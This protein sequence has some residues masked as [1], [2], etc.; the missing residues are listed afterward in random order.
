[1]NLSKKILIV[2]NCLLLFVS[3]L[4]AQMPSPV[5]SVRDGG[6]EETDVSFSRSLKFNNAPL[7]LIL[8][9]YSLVT[10]FTLLMAPGLPKVNITLKSQVP[11]TLDEYLQAIEAVLTMNG[12]G[13]M[14][15]GDSFVK[16]V[17]VK[18][19]LNTAPIIHANMPDK[20]FAE[21]D[22]IITQIIPLKH[23][24]VADAQKIVEGLKNTYGIIFLIEKTN[25]I[26]VMDNAANINRI[27]QIVE[28][29]DT[30]VE[31]REEPYTRSVLYAKASDIKKTIDTMV[32]DFQK[33]QTQSKTISTTKSSGS[34]GVQ[35]R[36]LPGVV[37]A[38]VPSTSSI[39]ANV[40]VELIEQAQKGVINGSVNVIA[41]DRTNKLIIIT[42]PENMKFFD[43]IIS[44]LDVETAPD[45]IVKVTRLEYAEAK[46]VADMLNYLIGAT[47]EDDEVKSVKENPGDGTAAKKLTE[48]IKETVNNKPTTTEATKSKVGELSEDSIKILSDERTNSLILMASR[49]DQITLEGIIKDMDMM[50]S[51]VLIESVIVEVT[52]GDDLQT[53]V[54]WI[55]NSMITYDKA[56]NGSKNPL[57]AF[58]GAGGGGF[59]TPIDA[60]VVAPSSTAGLTYYLSFFGIN[61]D[62]VIKM[63]STDNKSK[64]VSSPVIL[65]T[66]NTTAKITSTDKIYVLGS[67]TYRSSTEGGDIDNYDKMDV[68]LT[69]EVTPKINKN[70]VV[71]LEVS[72]VMSSPGATGKPQSG[73]IISSER[74]M[75]AAI[76]VRNGETIVFG[77]L[78]QN[79][80]QRSRTKIPLLGDIPLLGRLFNFT[81][82][83]TSK[84]ELIVFLTPY[85]LDT[86]DDIAYETARRKD[87]VSVQGEWPSGWSKSPVADESDS[88]IRSSRKKMDKKRTYSDEAWADPDLIKVEAQDVGD[89]KPLL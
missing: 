47:S 12:V 67:T 89:K 70:K 81:Q 85:V 23:I 82:D 42:R 84:K 45:V 52:L 63:V 54:D 15:T 48:V 66:D 74:S 5:S 10:G 69:L 27:I 75:D 28:Y 14:E 58:S 79:T 2:L 72:Q 65:T 17:P 50:L 64:I 6:V 24:A 57:F 83:T 56:Q 49:A 61:L 20:P 3:S 29:I 44:V 43:N 16:V 32:A 21:N 8:E 59:N 78:V 33:E 4:S 46:T 30:P 68:G 40:P 80:K 62:A 55:Q 88:G 7:D 71:L 76:A 86:P 19:L 31:R 9:D 73:S 60:S 18:N 38:R 53:G 36:T 39:A 13:L 37:R 25:S 34:P 35:R 11:L 77:G 1:M 41:D 26:L 51:Q 87:S 22:E